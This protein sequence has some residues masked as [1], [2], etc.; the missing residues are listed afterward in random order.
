MRSS[1]HVVIRGDGITGCALALGLASQGL[2]VGLVA[3][4]QGAGRP[5]DVRAYSLN[6]SARQLLESLQAW[7]DEP[8]ASAVRRIAVWGDAGGEIDFEAQA[9][10]A[11]SWIVDVPALE[12]LLRDRVRDQRGIEVLSAATPAELSVV[13]EG[14]TSDTRAALGIEYERQPYAQHALA[15]RVSHEQPHQAC[16]RQW[17]G[18]HGDQASILALL[19]LAEPHSSAVVWS[20]APALA[21][22]RC[23]LDDAGLAQELSRAVANALGTMRVIS[24]RAVWP[25]Q[26]AQARQWCGTLPDGGAFALVGDAAH[27]IHPLAGLGLNL[28]LNDVATLMG[29]LKRRQAE[30]QRSGA[31]DMALLREYQRQ[32]KLSVGS[33][34]GVCDGLQVLFSNPTGM[35]R[36]LRNT[37]LS[38][39]NR[40]GF[41]KQWIMAHATDLEMHS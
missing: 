35:A 34:N 28:G 8:H 22:S 31:G 13:C 17:F 23:E 5:E 21:R 32:R 2:R 3:S 30:G 14:R 11:L 20:Q 18:G 10:A 33:V 9:G 1:H 37:G 15:F 29:V 19:P 40:L 36:W 25:L 7:P 16:A 12:T 38:S 6:A 27:S 41:L 4:T 39:V 26:S 24:A